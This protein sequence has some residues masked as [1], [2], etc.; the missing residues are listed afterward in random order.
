M[1]D[2]CE[3]KQQSHL[4]ICDWYLFPH[5]N[6]YI[7][8]FFKGTHTGVL[9]LGR[10]NQPGSQT[11]IFYPGAD[12]AAMGDGGLPPSFP[13]WDYFV[14]INLIN[15]F[16]LFIWRAQVLLNKIYFGYC[17]TLF[18]FKGA[19]KAVRGVKA[20]PIWQ[21]HFY[22]C[23]PPGVERKSLSFSRQYWILLVC[24]LDNI[25]LQLYILCN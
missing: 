2:F 16:Y 13:V 7:Y 20:V 24:L 25:I 18:F 21:R 23:A 10:L 15:F 19:K 1:R 8:L 4:L 17:V 6:I 22:L 5:L 14:W 9:P 12:K 3:A 11:N